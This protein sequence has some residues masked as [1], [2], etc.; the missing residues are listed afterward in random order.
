MREYERNGVA[1]RG[2]AVR[3]RSPSNTTIHTLGHS[4]RTIEQF[5][6][7]LREYQIQVVVDVRSRPSSRWA[8]QF[9]RKTLEQTLS[10]HGVEFLFRGHNL[11]G[12]DDNVEY[13]QA[14]EEVVELAKTMRIVLLCAEADYTKCHRYTMLTPDLDRH[15]VVIKHLIWDK[16]TQK[17]VK[18]AQKSLFGG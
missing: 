1:S 6:G 14:I 3:H 8:P 17:P 12:L 13:D 16:N 15:N 9:N 11:G 4:N 10:E 5:L 7:K 2:L 18:T